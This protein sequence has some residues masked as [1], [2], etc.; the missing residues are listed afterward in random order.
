M[1]LVLFTE[2]TDDRPSRGNDSDL[3]MH[4]R[5]LQRVDEG[6]LRFIESTDLWPMQLAYGKE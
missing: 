5:K 2:K 6:Q 3:V 1:L 4:Q